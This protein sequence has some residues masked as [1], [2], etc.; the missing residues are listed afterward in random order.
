MREG[1]NHLVEH[2]VISS[3]SEFSSLD[4]WDKSLSN[5][6]LFCFTL[7]RR[8][9]NARETFVFCIFV[10]LSVFGFL[11]VELTHVLVS[12]VLIRKEH[13]TPYVVEVEYLLEDLVVVSFAYVVV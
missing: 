7:C 6:H 2:N 8:R 4:K 5:S 3:T 1:I 13:G 10:L 9:F 12:Y 11:N